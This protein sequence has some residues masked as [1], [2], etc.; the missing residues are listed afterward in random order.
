MD[1]FYM[2]LNM[3]VHLQ[4]SFVP[5]TSNLYTSIILP[6]SIAWWCH[7]HFHFLILLVSILFQCCRFCMTVFLGMF[8]I[9]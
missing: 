2:D 8:L 6:S 7:R 3:V 5:Q 1:S 4:R 9:L